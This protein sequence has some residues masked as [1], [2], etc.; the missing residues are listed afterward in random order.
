MHA[1]ASTVEWVALLL[2]VSEG[3]I[4]W[5]TI[6]SEISG[7]FLQ[8]LQEDLRIIPQMRLWQLTSISFLIHYSLIILPIDVT[9]S[10]LQTNLLINKRSSKW[11]LYCSKSLY[12]R[13]D[14]NKCRPTV[15]KCFTK[16]TVFWVVTPCNLER[17]QH[18]GRFY[19]LVL[20]RIFHKRFD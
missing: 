1:V 4:K 10:E 15:C 19:W 11:N 5:L 17:I 13:K 7:G 9:E 2:H 20:S 16:S 14:S 18:F 8:V 3:L 12:N 6:L